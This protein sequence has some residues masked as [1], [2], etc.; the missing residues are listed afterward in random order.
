MS[1][2]YNTILTINDQ[3]N[4]GN[5]L[6]NYALQQVL[7]YYGPCTTIHT[8]M[9]ADSRGKLLI[10]KVKP[11]IKQSIWGVASLSKKSRIMDARRRASFKEFTDCFVN[12]SLVSLSECKGINCA[13]DIEIGKI[14]I[15][16]DQVWNY[17]FNLSPGDLALRLGEFAESR[18]LIA[19]A[20]SIGL[21]DIDKTYLNVFQ[22]GLARIP[23]ISV[24][25]DQAAAIVSR[26]INRAV[27]VVLDPTL[28]VTAEHWERIIP[29]TFVKDDR[30]YV[31][32]YFLG[33]PTAKQESIIQNYAYKHSLRI[34]RI[35]DFHSDPEAY[36]AG[37]AEFVELF[38]KADYVFTDSYH[39]CC[40]SLLFEKQFK[41][42]NRN[43]S[44]HRNMNS[45]MKTLFRLFELDDVMDDDEQ[46]TIINY[47]AI[48]NLL[49]CH[50]AS[51]FEWLEAALR[52]DAA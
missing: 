47:L 17:T 40:F 7:G 2:R 24:R 9:H 29:G 46:I 15:G 37:P 36:S 33:A 22:H 23:Y 28:M 34:R 32:T 35:N 42:F 12:D 14:I 20:A 26:L 52:G 21:D 45:R 44:T 41:V 50:R 48:S 19:Y 3:N 8:Y 31:L 30:P 51:S 27:Q 6:Q 10:E 11:V 18:Q 5:R 25:E 4:Y 13:E 43:S 38:S 1:K 49:E 39:A 16:S